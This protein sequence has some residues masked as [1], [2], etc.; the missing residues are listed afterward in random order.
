[1]SGEALGTLKRSPRDARFHRSHPTDQPG[2]DSDF[3]EMLL[4]RPAQ[5]S[6]SSEG[7]AAA[8]GKA[9][10]RPFTACRS[11]PGSAAPTESQNV[12]GWQGPLW[13]TQS[14][15]LPKQGHP[16]QAAQ[17]LIQES[18]EYLQRR[19]LHSHPGQ[20]AGKPH[21]SPGFWGGRAG[22]RCSAP[23]AALLGGCKSASPAQLHQA[24]RDRVELSMAE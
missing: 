20:R 22:G 17:D 11:F 4:S 6:L 14:N 21:G 7:E 19:R 2:G 13:V 10:L 9:A 3:P 15:P 8:P 12:Q 24:R 5:R 23:R 16:E 18:L 1:M